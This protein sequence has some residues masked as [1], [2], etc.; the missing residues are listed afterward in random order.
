ME[1]WSEFLEEQEEEAKGRPFE[2]FLKWLKK[3]C[4][5]WE[6]FVAAGVGC[7]GKNKLEQHSFHA[8]VDDSSEMTCFGCGR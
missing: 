1:K 7:K 5:S 8:K 3:A 2:I 4:V 6:V